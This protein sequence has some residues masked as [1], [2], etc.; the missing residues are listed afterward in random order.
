[1]IPSSACQQQADTHPAGM[2]RGRLSYTTSW[3]MIRFLLLHWV[4]RRHSHDL[5]GGLE[6]ILYGG[7]VWACTA[8]NWIDLRGFAKIP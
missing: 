5:L 1:M 2:S 3:D 6:N 8:G 7:F 4:C